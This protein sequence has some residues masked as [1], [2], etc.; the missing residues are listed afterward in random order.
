MP[1]ILLMMSWPVLSGIRM[2]SRWFMILKVIS[3]PVLLFRL[4]MLI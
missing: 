2:M 1:V 4:L 3:F